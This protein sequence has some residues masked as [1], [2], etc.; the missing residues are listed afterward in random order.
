MS[1]SGFHS[2]YFYH[3]KACCCV[4]FTNYSNKPSDCSAFVWVCSSRS[5]SPENY[6]NQKSLKFQNQQTTQF[7][8]WHTKVFSE[9]AATSRLGKHV[10]G[11]A[12]SSINEQQ[13][14]IPDGMGSIKSAVLGGRRYQSVWLPSEDF[15]VCGETF[16]WH[17]TLWGGRV[18]HKHFNYQSFVIK[19][20]DFARLSPTF[21]WIM[22]K[23][24]KAKKIISNPTPARPSS[25]FYNE[26]RLNL[27]ALCS[28]A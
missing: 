1:L 15:C 7:V 11:S 14:R 26:Q 19:P 23:G 21:L 3:I 2:I 10:F 20:W 12:S 27:W 5:R 18:C 16:G 9:A 17:P 8:K 24:P 13:S 25:D 22:Q 28:T 4:L 6:F